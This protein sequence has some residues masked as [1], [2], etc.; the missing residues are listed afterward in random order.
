MQASFVKHARLWKTK[1]AE[2]PMLQTSY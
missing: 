1:Q 2:L